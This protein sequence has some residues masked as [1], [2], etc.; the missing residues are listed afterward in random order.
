MSINTYIIDHEKKLMNMG[1]REEIML[2]RE[3]INLIIPP[4]SVAT[5]LINPYLK[6]DTICRRRGIF[7]ST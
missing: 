5:R 7:I 1:G 4:K 2:E 6:G 3:T